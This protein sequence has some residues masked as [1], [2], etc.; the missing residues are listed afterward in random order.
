MH[1]LL[2]PLSDII[3]NSCLAASKPGFM[4]LIF[5]FTP[6]SEPPKNKS[7]VINNALVVKNK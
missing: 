7:L 3:T 4:L 5:G 6:T 2:K 1:S